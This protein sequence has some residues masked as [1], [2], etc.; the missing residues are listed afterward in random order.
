MTDCEKI[1]RN[2]QSGERHPE[3]PEEAA[4]NLEGLAL[5]GLDNQ[6]QLYW[7][8]KPVVITQRLTLSRWQKV[9]AALAAIAII[10]GGLGA[11][12]IGVDAGHSFGCKLEW[13]SVGCP[14][15]APAPAAAPVP[16]PHRL[17]PGRP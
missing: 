16:E 17:V 13:W 2:L 4:I 5:L 11:L 6:T 10:L 7:D 12:A 8:G 3:R 14:R 1:S 9:W 15:V